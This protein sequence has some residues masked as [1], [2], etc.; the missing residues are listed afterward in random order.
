MTEAT[1]LINELAQFTEKASLSKIIDD[2]ALELMKDV[3]SFGIRQVSNC[4]S[5]IPTL[6]FNVSK[7]SYLIEFKDKGRVF[8]ITR[9]DGEGG[10]VLDELERMTGRE[11]NKSTEVV[12]RIMDA[13]IDA[14]TIE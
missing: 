1:S 11:F 12:G 2:A 3:R 9:V 14:L 6:C 4:S 7:D 10:K 8:E 13:L 5:S